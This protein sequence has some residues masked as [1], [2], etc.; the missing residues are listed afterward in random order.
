MTLRVGLIGCGL[1][2]SVH[3]RSIG[4]LAGAGLVDAQVVVTHDLDRSRAEGLAALS[5]ATVVDD[6]E[7]VV[8]GADA[9][10]VCTPTGS[11]RRLV[12]LVAAGGTALFCEK[13]LATSLADAE[14]MAQAAAGIPNQVGLVLRHAPAYAALAAVVAGGSLGRPLAAV[15]RDDQYWPIQGQY[16]STWRG[17]VAQAGG[18]TLI[19]HSIH[20]LDVLGWLLGEAVSVSGRTVELGAHPG[21]EDVAVGTLVFASGAVATLTSVWHQVLSRSSNRWLEVLCE[22]GVVSVVREWAGPLTVTTSRGAETV[23]CPPPAWLAGLP[24]EERW[25]GAVAAYAPQALAF[26][27]AVGSGATPAPGLPVAVAAHRLAD[28]VYRSAATGG[29]AVTL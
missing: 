29:Q 2:G 15:F 4:A 24:V 5:G 3:A 9:V 12:D 22:H 27:T 19:E 10:Y 8:A 23:D 16:G 6:P 13:P 21:V 28:A 11:H 14:A 26:L 17:D 20:D 7:A 1:Q 25:Q 18:G